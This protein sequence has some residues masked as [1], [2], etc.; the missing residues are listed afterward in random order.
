MNQASVVVA[1]HRPGMIAGAVAPLLKDPATLEVVVVAID[2]PDV[3]ATAHAIGDPRVHVTTACA[4]NP[5]A[6][7]QIGVECARGDIVVMLDDDVLAG[8]GLISGHVRHHAVSGTV[9][10]GYMPIPPD[11]LRGAFRF[12]ARVYAKSYEGRVRWWTERP[13]LVNTGFWGG[14]TS[15]TRADALRIGLDNPAFPVRYYE[16]QEFGKRC[17]AA[18]MTAIFDHSLQATHLYERSISEWLLEG[19]RQGAA[20]ALLGPESRPGARHLPV[21]LLPAV[22]GAAIAAG[23]LGLR[24][25]ESRL[26]WDARQIQIFRGAREVARGTALAN[27]LLAAPSPPARTGRSEGDDHAPFLP[28]VSTRA[29]P[30]ARGLLHP[31]LRD[32]PEPPRPAPGS[33]TAGDRN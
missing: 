2:D 11:R 1:S 8:P 3:V 20:R 14:N 4:G 9:V 19:R 24:R 10:L 33:G 22:V 26:A 6:A 28:M 18:G 23:A 7:R 13:D 5:N 17:H 16:D 32:V 21:V 27:G 30:A 29:A 31:M 12:P 25:I 15:M